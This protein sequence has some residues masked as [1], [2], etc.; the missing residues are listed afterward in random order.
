MSGNPTA[1]FLSLVIDFPY[2]ILSGLATDSVMRICVKL[3]LHQ[4]I[5]ALIVWRGWEDIYLS[6]SYHRRILRHSHQADR[7]NS[8]LSIF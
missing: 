6:L 4:M 1:P 5:S 2:A 3:I 7:L 8:P